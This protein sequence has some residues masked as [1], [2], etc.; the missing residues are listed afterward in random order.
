MLTQ[1]LARLAVDDRPRTAGHKRWTVEWIESRA[2]ELF[3]I[4]HRRFGHRWITGQQRPQRRPRPGPHSTRDI[5]L[6]SRLKRVHRLDGRRAE[7]S[8][9]RE[10]R[11]WVQAGIERS[12]QRLDQPPAGTRGQ[13]HRSHLGPGRIEMQPR[14][15]RYVGNQTPGSVF[16]TIPPVRVLGSQH[17]D[18]NRP[19]WRL[20]DPRIGSDPRHR[21]RLVSHHCPLGQIPRNPLGALARPQVLEHQARCPLADQ[22]T[23][24]NRFEQTG[25]LGRGRT[26]Q[27]ELTTPLDVD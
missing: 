14:L 1:H 8:V 7:F 26:A 11:R 24:A 22:A 27:P 10:F 23:T 12:L 19:R 13:C 17:H 21:P 3:G 18:D 25:R 9:N 5:H 2:V 6:L 20:H 16:R 15:A 4:D